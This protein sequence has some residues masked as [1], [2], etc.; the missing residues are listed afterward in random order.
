MRTLVPGMRTPTSGPRQAGNGRCILPYP[1]PLRRGRN[2]VVYITNGHTLSLPCPP[3]I[4][5]QIVA[6]C[7]QALVMCGIASHEHEV[8]AE[9]GR[10]DE[11]IGNAGG[12]PCAQQVAV[13]AS[14]QRG[15]LTIDC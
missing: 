5:P 9:G 7:L 12:L 1:S 11:W 14:G 10:G 8:M 15:N 3:V 13:H 4:E 6:K 2:A